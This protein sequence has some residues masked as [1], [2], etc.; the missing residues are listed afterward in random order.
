MKPVKVPSERAPSTC[1][2][3]SGPITPLDERN[4]NALDTI[5]E[6]PFRASVDTGEKVDDKKA[7]E[8]SI[9]PLKST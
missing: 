9:V 5:V 2:R 1:R 8:E 4:T 3:A 6:I 7:S